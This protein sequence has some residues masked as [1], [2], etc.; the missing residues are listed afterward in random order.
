MRFTRRLLDRR[1]SAALV[2]LSCAAAGVCVSCSSSDDDKRPLESPDAAPEAGASPEDAGPG[3][4]SPLRDAAVHDAAPF[5]GGPLPIVCTEPPCAT[6]LTTTLRAS[7]S[8]RGEGFCALL[9]DGTVACWG[10]NLGG[11][12]GRGEDAG[13]DDSSLPARVAGLSDI[14]QLDHTCAVDKAGESWCWGTGPFL[15]STTRPTTLERTP[16]KLPISPAKHVGMGELTACAVVS[17]GVICWGENRYAQVEPIVQATRYA[18]HPPQAIALPSGAPIRDLVVGSASFVLRED[19]TAASWGANASIG[20]VSS[21]FPDPY[22]ASVELAGLTSIDIVGEDVCA[23]AGGIGYCWG[24]VIPKPNGATDEGPPIGRASPEPVLVPEP[25][26][27]MAVTRTSV[28]YGAGAP[29][30]E[31]YRWCAVSAEGH[32]YCWGANASGQAG[33]GTKEYAFEAVLTKGLPAPAVQ[34]K[35]MPS[36]TC[37]LLTTGKIYC[38]GSNFNGQLGNGRPKGASVVPQEVVLP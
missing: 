5:D 37:A 15:R 27:Q 33:N 6:S 28:I 19:R 16:V 31:P 26:V 13:A 11:Q 22:A 23:A 21:I 30:V 24:P 34:V 1:S 20:R 18:A 32:V 38:W 14:V 35:T 36:S 25:V 8:D 29:I 10:A 12:L 7:S 3:D 9:D 17:D 4:A 2:L